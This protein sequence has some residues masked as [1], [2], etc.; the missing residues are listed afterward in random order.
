[1]E[2]VL[3]S[4]RGLLELSSTHWLLVVHHSKGHA[5]PHVAAAEASPLISLFLPNQ[6]DFAPLV[7]L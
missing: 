5:H 4:I 3:R 2:T 1:M 7:K 6:T